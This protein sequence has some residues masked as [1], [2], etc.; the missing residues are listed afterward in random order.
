MQTKNKIILILISILLFCTTNS[1]L[2]ADEFN[3]SALEI[4]VDKENNIVI[5]KG[6]V[7]ITDTSGKLIKSDRATY[8][9]NDEL[10]IAEGSV[11]MLDNE[12]NILTSDKIIYNKKI[13][14]I[15]ARGNSKLIIKEGYELISNEIFY[16]QKKRIY[17][18]LKNSNSNAVL[19]FN[20]V[21]QK[22]ING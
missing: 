4:T 11:E 1:K 3:I 12:G 20:E 16:E 13:D 14:I 2:Y 8:I 22:I 18:A 7:E 9:K 17:K 21:I 15:N 6:S 10:L 19:N 5:G